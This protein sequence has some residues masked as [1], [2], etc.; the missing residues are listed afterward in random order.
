MFAFPFWLFPAFFL[1]AL[2]YA[3]V[4]FGGGSSYLAFLAVTSLRLNEVVAIALFC[5]LVVAGGGVWH[6]SKAGQMR[7]KML[8]PFLA[9]SIPAAYLGGLV[10]T[11]DSI[12]RMLLGICLLFVAWRIWLGSRN[13]VDQPRKTDGVIFMAAAL[14]VGGGLGFLSGFL[15]IGGGIFL[16]PLLILAGWAN[17]KE[18]SAA[19]SLFILLN[20]AAGLLARWHSLQAHFYECILLGVVV[21]AGGQIGSRTG[22]YRLPDALMRKILA[23]FISW[24]SFRLLWVTL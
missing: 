20:S 21:F 10:K 12:H 16:S 2:I 1:T 23:G 7:G 3:I 6:F 11:E 24:V 4:G 17:A 14:A 9:S 5:N 15:G 13:T 19:A 8:L 18:S 22:A